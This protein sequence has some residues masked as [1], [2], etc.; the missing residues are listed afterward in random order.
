M[1]PPNSRKRV[2]IDR[3]LEKKEI[4]QDEA[5]DLLT[6]QHFI[7]PYL[8]FIQD[9]PSPAPMPSNIPQ[10]V[11]QKQRWIN[12]ELEKRADFAQRCS[13]NPANGG[14][15]LCGCTMSGAVITA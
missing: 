10:F 13:C 8:P 1:T 6:E 15:G 14:S 12:D 4:T 5:L 2:I 11:D 9:Y 3:L 7:V